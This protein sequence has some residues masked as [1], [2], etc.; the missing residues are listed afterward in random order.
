MPARPW[1]CGRWRVDLQHFMQYVFDLVNGTRWDYTINVQFLLTREIP[2]NTII[3]KA[4]AKSFQTINRYCAST[5][6]VCG[7]MSQLLCSI[8]YTSVVHIKVFLSLNVIIT[9]L[10]RADE[11]GL[12]VCWLLLVSRIIWGTGYRRNTGRRRNSFCWRDQTRTAYVSS[13]LSPAAASRSRGRA[14]PWRGNEMP[15]F[16]LLVQRLARKRLA[17]D[18]DPPILG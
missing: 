12:R 10:I 11:T 2:P 7:G 16:Q 3:V 13:R 15:G 14:G 9:L 6:M 18:R 4:H 1:R 8:N 5:M 17:R